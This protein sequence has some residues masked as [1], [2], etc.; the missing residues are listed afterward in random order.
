MGCFHSI[1]CG[2]SVECFCP[3]ILGIRM[4]S[5]RFARVCSEMCENLRDIYQTGA[6]DV[7]ENLGS[8]FERSSPT[9]EIIDTFDNA[10]FVDTTNECSDDSNAEKCV[11]RNGIPDTRV[12]TD[13]MKCFNELLA[14]GINARN[15]TDRVDDDE[16]SGGGTK[17]AAS[18]LDYAD[19]D[20]PYDDVA[21]V[22]SQLKCSQDIELDNNAP[23]RPKFLEHLLNRVVS[24]KIGRK[25]ANGLIPDTEEN[26]DQPEEPL[27]PDTETCLQHAEA[28]VEELLVSSVRPPSGDSSD[29]GKGSLLE[30]TSDFSPTGTK[31]KCWSTPASPTLQGIVKARLKSFQALRES[32]AESVDSQQDLSASASK[33]KTYKSEEFKLEIQEINK[34]IKAF[35]TSFSDDER[36]NS[37]VMESG[38]VKALVSKINEN[39]IK[40][41]SNEKDSAQIENGAASVCGSD[42]IESAETEEIKFQLGKEDSGWSE[43]DQEIG[44]YYTAEEDNAGQDSIFSANGVTQRSKEGSPTS[45]CMLLR[46]SSNSSSSRHSSSSLPNGN[47][48][49]ESKEED[50][51]PKDKVHQI[52]YELLTTE[53]AYVARLRLLE[54][55]FHT[56]IKE[57]NTKSSFMPSE[58][59][60]QMFSAIKPIYDFHMQFLLPDLEDRM[61]NWSTQQKISDIMA[62]LAP[63]LLLYTEYVKNYDN[64][65]LLIN[66]WTSQSLKFA[67]ILH[68]IQRLPECGQL[69][70]QHHMLEPIQRVP[71]YELLLKAYI[72]SLTAE[73]PDRK[74]AEKALDR[75]TQATSH[76][77]TA[78]KKLEKFHKLLNIVQKLRGEEIDDLI[79]PTRE[80][81]KEGTITKISARGGEKQS[82]YLFLFNDLLL[83]C[84]EQNITSTYK[85]RA[86]LKVDGMEILPGENFNINNTFCVKGIEKAIEFLDESNNG[87]GSDWLAVFQ[88]VTTDFHQ[89]MKLGRLVSW[90]SETAPEKPKPGTKA[91]RW[92]KDDEVT[93][94]HECKD[95]FTAIK[96]RHHCRACGE[97]FCNKCSSDRVFLQWENKEN[98]VCKECYNQILGEENIQKKKAPAEVNPE[99]DSVMS[100]YMHI[101]GKDKKWDKR[102]VSAKTDFVM[103]IYKKH[104]DPKAIQTIPLPGHAVKGVGD[105]NDRQHV[106]ALTHKEITVCHFQ[107]DSEEDMNQWVHALENL[108]LAEV[109]TDE[110]KRISTHS[111]SSSQSTQSSNSSDQSCPS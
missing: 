89:K 98:R 8:C 104:K 12:T 7:Q 94:C 93:M 55:V 44:D 100:G 102:W 85:V 91:P 30:Q 25:G 108:A 41:A 95:K 11:E 62:K 52:A 92:I 77:N 16:G 70:L 50:E 22:K 60:V 35:Y 40:Q 83:V 99:K 9:D 39:K 18:V 49:S 43:Y 38:Y 74:D 81:I 31:Q 14:L 5:R 61:K 87:N 36:F 90:E 32:D 76:A 37:K 68:E 80:L 29:S 110:P 96:R 17:V 79:L 15:E 10:T 13:L 34:S 69:T 27:S 53:R 46:N 26:P 67:G 109:P 20:N 21:N 72:K 48:V 65:M 28:I 4:A 54:E 105:C 64:T 23:G 6:S 86:T 19:D 47:S 45:S 33:G 73:A 78:I 57:E 58:V 84:S 3:N 42:G 107:V 2:C 1:H 24:R 75:V 66:K 88:Q 56:R 101:M 71:R 82:R 63:F 51:K 111:D 97:I 103:Y 106:F 59:V